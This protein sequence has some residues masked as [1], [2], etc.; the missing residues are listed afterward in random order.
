MTLADRLR[1]DAT[2]LRMMACGE[3]T[4][5]RAEC[6]EIGARLVAYANAIDSAAVRRAAA[7]LKPG[8]DSRHGRAT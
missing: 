2:L 7:V 4:M 5:S 8:K 1:A 6:R 3:L